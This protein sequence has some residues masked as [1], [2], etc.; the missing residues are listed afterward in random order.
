MNHKEIKKLLKERNLT[1][2]DI[3]NKLGVSRT[4][5]SLVI[6][7]RSVSARIRLAI[8]KAIGKPVEEVFPHG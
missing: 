3:A 2:V 5:V 4:S 6:Y 8:A 7:R 1:M